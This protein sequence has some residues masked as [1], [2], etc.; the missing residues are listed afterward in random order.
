MCL[1][2]VSS[3]IDPASINIKDHLLKFHDWD[4][5]NTFDGNPVF[6]NKKNNDIYL[7]TIKDRKIFR[8]NLDKEISEKLNINPE[9]AIF[10]SRHNSEMKKPSMTVHPIGNYQNADYGGLARTVVPSSPKMMTELLRIIKKRKKPE[11]E[12]DI[13]FEVTHH[14]PY[15][16]IPT[17]FVEIGSSEKQWKDEVAGTIVSKSLL[18]LLEKYSSEDDIKE[19]MTVLLGFGGGHYAPR[20]SD[21]VFEKKAAFGHM[22]PS[23]HINE[24]YIDEEIIRKTIDNTPNINGVYIHR[25]SLKKS[26]ITEYKKIFSD[27][28]LPV[29]SSKEL[30]SI[31]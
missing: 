10:I 13:C 21:V 8:E 28:D 11:L 17:F 16:K 30:T 19:K 31:S 7:I 23:Y 24:G 6:I 5:I 9:L 12:Y 20:F 25:K 14:G 1:I 22:I 18:E 4:E 2:I 26:Q 15:L 27:I 29:F 3:Q